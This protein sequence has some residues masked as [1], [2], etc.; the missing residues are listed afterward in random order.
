MEGSDQYRDEVPSYL[1]M[2]AAG[3]YEVHVHPDDPTLSVWI[4]PGYSKDVLD[5][6]LMPVSTM[7]SHFE[8]RTGVEYPWGEYRQVFVQ[9]FLYGGM[10]NTSATINT[11]TLVVGKQLKRLDR[12][13][14]VLW[15][16]NWLISG[17]A[18]ISRV[19]LGV[20]FGS[21][22]DSRHL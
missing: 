2:V 17:L 18:T 9:R 14:R 10:E 13:S 6:I 22:R 8:D 19:E 20:N 1:I 15:L 7:K 21:T 12:V 4:H 11:D 3:R 16:T 5:G